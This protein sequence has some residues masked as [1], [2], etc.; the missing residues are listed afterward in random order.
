MTHPFHP[1]EPDALVPD[2][3]QD[4]QC[5]CLNPDDQYLLEIDNGAVFLVHKACGKQPAGDYTDLVEMRPIP[6]TLTAEPY[7]NCDGR[8]WHGDYRCD[9]GVALVAT[10]NLRSVPGGQLPFTRNRRTP[11]REL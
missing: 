7:G 6:V 10:I 9:C 2:P 3:T 1:A 11:V 8:E 4:A 5:A